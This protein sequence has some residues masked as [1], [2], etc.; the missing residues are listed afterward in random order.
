MW[1]RIF[2]VLDEPSDVTDAPTAV[3]MGKV[4]EEVAFEGVTFVYQRGQRVAL[5]DIN[6]NILPGQMVALVGPSGAGKTT[7]SNLVARFYDPQEGR[8]TID[9]HDLRG[10]TLASV[11]SAV[12]LVLQDTFLFHATIRENLLYGRPD[13]NEFELANAVRDAALDPVIAALP[14][15]YETVIGDRGHRLSGGE[16]QRVAIARAI[17]KD[18]AIL[19]LDEATSHLDSISEDLIQRALASLFVGRTAR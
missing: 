15:G 6:L 8:V 7:L 5:R 1:R 18:P 16:R 9:G 17:L 14:D 19:V 3:A 10:V 11:S 13:A 2:E 4:R 12:G